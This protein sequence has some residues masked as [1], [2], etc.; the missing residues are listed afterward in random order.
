L[1]RTEGEGGSG[2]GGR[3]GRVKT[4]LGGEVAEEEGG[5]GLV[6][7]F[8]GPKDRNLSEDRA[9]RGEFR[10]ERGGAGSSGE[11]ESLGGRWEGGGLGE[12]GDG[13][14]DEG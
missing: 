7:G 11:A 3:P 10:R 12:G 5:G 4:A 8:A 9:A 6:G 1:R 14:W 13:I 2:G